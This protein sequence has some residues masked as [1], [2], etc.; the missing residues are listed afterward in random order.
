MQGK[1]SNA[2][3]RRWTLEEEK[4]LVDGVERFGKG[5]WKQI[6]KIY[7]FDRN[8][9]AL[10]SK[11]QR[12][13]QQL[14]PRPGNEADQQRK[15]RCVENDDEDSDDLE[16]EVREWAK[17]RQSV[18][19]VDTLRN[20]VTESQPRTSQGRAEGGGMR[21]MD[22]V[23]EEGSLQRKRKR[24]SQ[25]L[26]EKEKEREKEKEHHHEGENCDGEEV[27]NEDS[28]RWNEAQI[29]G[30][31]RDYE[32]GYDGEETD[33]LDWLAE[34]DLPHPTLDVH[35]PSSSPPIYTQTTTTKTTTLQ[36]TPPFP[37]TS[38][39]PTS[40]ASP[41]S[42]PPP[43][44]RR[45]S[46]RRST[47]LHDMLLAQRA[48]EDSTICRTVPPPSAPPKE[49]E[50]RRREL[51]REDLEQI[52]QVKQRVADI[53]DDN[54]IYRNVMKD[55]ATQLASMAATQQR[56]ADTLDRQAE[57]HISFLRWIRGLE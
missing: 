14:P 15:R 23:E 17:S 56:L 5:K 13:Q 16:E 40:T 25:N 45:K 37:S 10:A 51:E 33:Y 43:A 8:N 52:R 30:F 24:D 38:P 12:L 3:G 20:K 28:A 50:Y 2:K 46:V 11:Y 4:D 39:P 34:N 57:A 49:L 27:H 19:P 21:R 55:F 42:K 7:N 47:S 29:R 6:R 32:E 48:R 22:L 31:R 18:K 54:S 44:A 53:R 35:F 26:T 1:K 36:V 41:T 9:V